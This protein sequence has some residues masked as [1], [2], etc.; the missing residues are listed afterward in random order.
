MRIYQTFQNG[1]N[2]N[3]CVCG[4]GG[5]GR[6]GGGGGGGRVSERGLTYSKLQY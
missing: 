2:K 6:G 5:M 4:G 1:E 3:D